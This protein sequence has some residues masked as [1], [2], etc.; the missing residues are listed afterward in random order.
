MA[1]KKTTKHSAQAEKATGEQAKPEP[2]PRKINDLSIGDIVAIPG[3]DGPPTICDAARVKDGADAGKFDVSLRNEAGEI[4]TARFAA[5]EEVQVVGKATKGGKD[6]AVPAASAALTV[7]ALTLRTLRVTR[8]AGG[9][10]NFNASIHGAIA[11]SFRLEQRFGFGLG[12]F[13]FSFYAVFVRFFFV[14]LMLG[15]RQHF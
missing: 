10:A 15:A 4:E 14:R 12:V 2:T 5:D 7:E 13:D 11:T 3:F 6:G 8:A 9:S 1:A